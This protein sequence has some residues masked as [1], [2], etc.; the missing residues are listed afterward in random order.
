MHETLTGGCLCGAVRYRVTGPLRP[1][2]ACHCRQCQKTSG[3]HV[4]ATRASKQQVAFLEDRGL[5]WYP[6]SEIAR[7]GFCRECGGN[8][9]YERLNAD[10]LSIMAGTLDQPCGLRLAGHIFVA[11][12]ADYYDIADGLP[13]YDGR[14][15]GA[16]SRRDDD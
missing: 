16:L 8:L 6:S 15:D 13:C 5:A 2:V 4:A 10:R 14:D 1:V 11:D 9:F 12:K 7:R 3:H